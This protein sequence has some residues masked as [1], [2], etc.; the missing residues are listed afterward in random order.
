MPNI[1]RFLSLAYS[2]YLVKYY[3]SKIA[4]IPKYNYKNRLLKQFFADYLIHLVL[5]TLPDFVNIRGA[6]KMRDRKME[7]QIWGKTTRWKMQDWKM[8]DHGS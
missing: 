2:D 3:F 4:I 1:D 5:N 6:L 7:E 8:E